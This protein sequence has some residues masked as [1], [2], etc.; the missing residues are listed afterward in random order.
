MALDDD[1]LMSRASKQI[2][3]TPTTANNGKVLPYGLGWF[4]QNRQGIKLVWHGGLWKPTISALFLTV[5]E[6]RLAFIALATTDRLS[7][8]YPVL[9]GG[10]VTGSPYARAFLSRFVV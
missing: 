6:N 7:S 2:L 8:P 10:D 5:P 3:F 9:G 1:V 4:V